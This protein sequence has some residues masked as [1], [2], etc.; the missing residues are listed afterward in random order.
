MSNN[1]ILSVFRF[2]LMLLFTMLIIVVITSGHH[3]I[4]PHALNFVVN[5]PAISVDKRES[6]AKLLTLNFQGLLVSCLCCCQWYYSFIR[7]RMVNKSFITRFPFFSFR[8][9]FPF[10]Y[11]FHGFLVSFILAFLFFS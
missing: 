10:F 3:V 11:G 7:D 2:I 6:I 8:S 9:K 1:F 5:C 4:Y